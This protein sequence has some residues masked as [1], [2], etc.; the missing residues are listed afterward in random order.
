[1]L[2]TRN[3]GDA[4]GGLP[5]LAREPSTRAVAVGETTTLEVPASAFEAVLT[6]NFSL[7]RTML[8]QLGTTVLAMRG[9]L[10]TVPGD[11]STL[12]VQPP[13][14]RTVFQFDTPAPWE[15]Q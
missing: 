8:R 12:D 6:T 2:S 11:P 9:N 13:D 4:Y 7:L 3:A 15:R 14:D 10:P 5:L 1:M